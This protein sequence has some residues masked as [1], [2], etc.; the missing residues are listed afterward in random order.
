MPLPIPGIAARIAIIAPKV[1]RIAKDIAKATGTAGLE[2][3][4]KGYAV[5][6]FSQQGVKG[7]MAAAPGVKAGIYQFPGGVGGAIETAKG[8]GAQAQGTVK[9]IAVQGRVPAGVSS[10][11]TKLTPVQVAQL[12]AQQ[13]SAKQLQSMQQE[14][15]GQKSSKSQ[16]TIRVA[17]YTRKDGKRVAAYTRTR[18]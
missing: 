3:K 2:Y 16:K 10:L 17:A 15:E 1:I 11:G 18:G 9:G 7:I 14:L 13:W 4:A 12:L 5:G 8:W 6:G